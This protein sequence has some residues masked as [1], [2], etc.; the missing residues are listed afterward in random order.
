MKT[1]MKQLAAGTFIAFLFL[2][3]N[4]NAKGTETIASG[5]ESIESSL[6]IEK[7]MTDEFLWDSNFVS[8]SDFTHETEKTIEIENWMTGY[9]IWTPVT[10]FVEETET[11]LELEKWMTSD[12]TRNAITTDC[13]TEL[14]V[15]KWMTENN[16]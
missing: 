2:V 13:D 14:T 3:G 7:W 12:F 5:H 4:V 1:K 16:I 9:E 15:E 6:Q 10:G 8:L 11:G